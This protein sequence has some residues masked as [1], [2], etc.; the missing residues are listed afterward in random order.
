MPSNIDADGILDARVGPWLPMNPD[1]TYTRLGLDGATDLDTAA[2]QHVHRR[3]PEE[4]RTKARVLA[5]FVGRR[6]CWLDRGL[7]IEL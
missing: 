2:L 3:V 6:P 4:Y 7:A 1:Y 5:V